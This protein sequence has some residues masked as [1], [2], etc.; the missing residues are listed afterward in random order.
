MK[1]KSYQRVLLFLLA[2][3]FFTCALSPW[4]AWSWNLIVSSRPEW[5]DWNY[6]FSRI[7]NRLFMVL[8]IVI[9]F[10]CLRF[11]KIRSAAQLGLSNLRR[12]YGDVL[13]GV[14][15]AVASFAVVVGIMAVVNVFHPTLRLAFAEGMARILEAVMAG[16]TV[17]VIEEV[18]FRGMIFKGLRE[19]WGLWGA[20]VAA[21]AFYAA[22]HF[23]KPAQQ[24][25]PEGLNPWL[26]FVHLAHTFQLFMDPAG[27]VAG[28]F[29]L[30]LLGLVLSYAFVRT[31]SLYL[32]IGL[33]MG[34]VMGIKTIKVYGTYTRPDLGWFF[35][36]TDPKFVSGVVTW[37]GFVAVALVVHRLTRNRTNLSSDPPPAVAV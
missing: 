11:L 35:G 24:S 8:G 19:D 20:Y 28:F 6:S 15:L 23:I 30:F 16:L 3:L 10:P 26:G 5:Q 36:S 37:V 1:L 9:F 25:Y 12:D 17:G 31:G 32:S 22:T 27:I 21:N 13:T 4:A 7:F 18:F 33:H 2:V 14:F 34:W 29:G